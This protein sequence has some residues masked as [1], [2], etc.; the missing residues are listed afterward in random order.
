LPE[1][2]LEQLLSRIDTLANE[3][4]SKPPK[5]QHWSIVERAKGLVEYV[6]TL[7]SI[8]HGV[9]YLAEHSEKLLPLVKAAF[10]G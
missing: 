10:G 8:N 5:S 9:H 2:Q 6:V 3:I 1:E 7:V 4:S